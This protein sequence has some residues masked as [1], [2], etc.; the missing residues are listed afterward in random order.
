MDPLF[1]HY[2]L[3]H[4]YFHHHHLIQRV[5]QLVLDKQLDLVLQSYCLKELVLDEDILHFYILHLHRRQW[6]HQEQ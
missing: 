3:E 4:L 6:L 1:L 5:D 2:Y